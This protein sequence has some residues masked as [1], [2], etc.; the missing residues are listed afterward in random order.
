MKQ[1]CRY[2][3]HICTGNGIWC[4]EKKKTLSE[5]TA[6]SV[7]HCKQFDFNFTDAF[8]ENKEAYRPREQYKPRQ[9]VC[10]E[11]TGNQMLMEV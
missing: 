1:Y 4:D 2:C 5:S 11:V 9:A 6:K 10:D 8:F 7:N 3:S